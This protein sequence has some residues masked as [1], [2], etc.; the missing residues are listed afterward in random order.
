MRHRCQCKRPP[1]EATSTDSS[2]IAHPASRA[3]SGIFVESLFRLIAVGLFRA[4]T[5]V[6][7]SAVRGTSRRSALLTRASLSRGGKGGEQSS[8]KEHR[9]H[10]LYLRPSAL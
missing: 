9:P 6:E 5:G 1:T 8:A 4:H 2:A 7:G 10:G 3:G